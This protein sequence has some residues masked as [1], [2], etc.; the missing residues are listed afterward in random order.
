MIRSVHDDIVMKLNLHDNSYQ[1]RLE[2]LQA[3]RI[4]QLQLEMLSCNRLLDV[5]KDLMRVSAL[6]AP[7]L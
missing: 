3:A 1:N 6:L 4:C 5:K 7:W 2:L